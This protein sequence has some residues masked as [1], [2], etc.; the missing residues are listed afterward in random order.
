MHHGVQIFSAAV[1]KVRSGPRHYLLL[2][3]S[4][5]WFRRDELSSPKVGQSFM[6]SVMLI[7]ELEL[8]FFN[9]CL[10]RVSLLILL[11]TYQ[12]RMIV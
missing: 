9:S 8:K 11:D 7:C 3:G 2:P 10:R 5:Q 1:A 12:Q 6:S 4:M